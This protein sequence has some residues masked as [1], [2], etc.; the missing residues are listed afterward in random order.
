[1]TFRELT[2]LQGKSQNAA[3]TS[4]ITHGGNEWLKPEMD[5]SWRWITDREGLRPE[6][7]DKTWILSGDGSRPDMDRDRILMDDRR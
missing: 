5:R 7:D 2:V 6:M 1:M 4:A 3:H